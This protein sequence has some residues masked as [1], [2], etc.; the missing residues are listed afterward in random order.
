MKTFNLLMLLI[1]FFT[2]H[3]AYSQI[4]TTVLIRFI[5]VK[6]NV[7]LTSPKCKVSIWRMGHYDKKIEG[8]FSRSDLILNK[9]EV[10]EFWKQ[11]FSD[12]VIKGN[13]A[14]LVWT[15]ADRNLVCVGFDF[16]DSDDSCNFYS[17][18]MRMPELGRFK[19]LKVNPYVIY[20]WDFNDEIADRGR[21]WFF[22]D[23]NTDRERW[24]L[25]K[26]SDQKG[27]DEVK[28][29]I[30]YSYFIDYPYTGL[31]YWPLIPIHLLDTSF[32]YPCYVKNEN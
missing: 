13:G 7:V 15:E 30:S 6:N 12:S 27:F 5:I 3:K 19:F 24:F 11:E 28:S 10:W 18:K 8:Y 16:Y 21:R 25:S 9:T 1:I 29:K 4:D 26:I 2:S 14:G 20:I 31:F 32:V 17:F 22:N 23:Q